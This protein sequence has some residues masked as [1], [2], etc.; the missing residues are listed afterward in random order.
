MKKNI[1]IITI[2]SIILLLMQRSLI[3]NAGQDTGCTIHDAVGHKSK[4]GVE[5][6]GDVCK[7]IDDNKY[8][9]APEENV[10]D[11]YCSTC[12]SGRA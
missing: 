11:Y 1:F 10:S 3:A 12:L 9:K 4:E 2:L 8:S 7:V 5:D 6:C